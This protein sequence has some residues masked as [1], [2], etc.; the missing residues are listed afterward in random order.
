MESPVLECINPLQPLASELPFMPVIGCKVP[1][2]WGY[3]KAT[4]SCSSLISKGNGREKAW[5]LS[6]AYWHAGFN[7]SALVD[8]IVSA[9]FEGCLKTQIWATVCAV[10]LPNADKTPLGCVSGIWA[11]SGWVGDRYRRPLQRPGYGAMCLEWAWYDTSLLEK[12]VQA[13][14]R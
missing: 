4:H 3:Q 9:S 5:Q 13:V 11:Q 10:I 2:Q 6:F 12:S 7:N 14:Q 1:S 8:W